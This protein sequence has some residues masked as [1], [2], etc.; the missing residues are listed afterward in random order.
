MMRSMFAGVSGLRNH[1]TMMDV[2]GN[3]IANVNTTG[4]KASQV[5][6]AEAISQTLSGASA[7]TL[8]RA[9]INPT[10]IG[11]GTSLGSIDRVF[12][13]GASQVTGRTTDLAI[14][15]DGFFIVERDGERSY[16]R[17]GVF[18]FD[19][20]GNLTATGGQ[21]VQGWLA[22]NLGVIDNNRPVAKIVLPTGQLV[23]PDPTT[24]VNIGGNLSGDLSIGEGLQSSI[25]IYDSL[26]A[27][28][29]AQFTFT[30][31]GVNSWTLTA[32]IAGNVLTVADPTVTFDGTGTLTSGSVTTLTGYTP[33]GANPLSFTVDLTS[34]ANLAQYGGQSNM[35]ARSADGSAIGT[36][37]G[38]SIGEDGAIEGQFSNGKT[39]LLAQLATAVFANNGG[40]LHSGD[41]NFRSTT[42]S[43]APLIGETGTSGRGLLSAGTLEMSNVDLAREFTN[44]IIA[45]RGFQANSRVITTSDELLAD[46]VNLKR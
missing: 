36:L 14:Q 23:D 33:P 41:G 45:Q 22:D 26:G 2:V 43:G 25:T 16:T 34:G 32:E 15:G 1:Q 3:N 4:F 29:E 11:L 13:Q 44:L 10:Q 12:T 20:V 42:Q 17:S 38:Y 39:Q 8:T 6:F 5:T 40:L 18:N 19:D 28:H 9:G 46:L 7:S 27:S 35:E 24:N 37:I 30:K 21:R 31:A